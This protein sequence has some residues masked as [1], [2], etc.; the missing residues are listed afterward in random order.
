MCASV[1]IAIDGT[2]T[3]ITMHGPA[4][5]QVRESQSQRPNRSSTSS[6]VIASLEA[7]EPKRASGNSCNT[8]RAVCAIG[9]VSFF[10]KEQA[11]FAQKEILSLVLILAF[12]G[13][14]FF[15]TCASRKNSL[16]AC[17]LDGSV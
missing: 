3:T 14:S 16:D 6:A 2:T 7:I 1:V 15:P 8:I 4:R 17:R 9:L 10:G 5:Q 12:I 11:C 13:D